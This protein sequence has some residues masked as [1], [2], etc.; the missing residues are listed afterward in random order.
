M[1]YD[2][3]REFEMPK[4]STWLEG[5]NGATKR[6][7]SAPGGQRGG[8]KT[9]ANKDSP[10]VNSGVGFKL[11]TTYF[12]FYFLKAQKGRRSGKRELFLTLG[13]SAI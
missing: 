3:Q 13:F 10:K 6:E 1:A 4:R 2:C 8:K 9:K 11:A 12:L 7:N 5:L